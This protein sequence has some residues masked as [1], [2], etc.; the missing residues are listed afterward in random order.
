MGVKSKMYL[1]TTW[2]LKVS[3]MRKQTHVMQM[4][5]RDLHNHFLNITLTDYHWQSAEQRAQ[6]VTATLFGR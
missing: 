4:S 5:A 6:C 3:C 2:K 1:K